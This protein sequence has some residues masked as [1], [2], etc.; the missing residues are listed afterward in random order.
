AATPSTAPRCASSAGRPSGT[1][2]RPSPRP[3]PGTRTTGAGGSASARDRR[4][5]R[6]PPRRRHRPAASVRVLLPGAGGQV[7]TELE[8]A[9][10]GHEVVACDRARLDVADRDS[11]LAAITSTAPDA[12]VHAAAWTDV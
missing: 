4:A 9:F 7:G 2:T 10:A 5:P 3:S 8:R 6:P 11:V 1:S 12:V